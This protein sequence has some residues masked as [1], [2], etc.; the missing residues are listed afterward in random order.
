MQRICAI[1]V[2]NNNNDNNNN[3]N[4]NAQTTFG[5]QHLL[6]IKLEAQVAKLAS[7]QVIVLSLVSDSQVCC[8][9]FDHLVWL[10]LSHSP[11]LGSLSQEWL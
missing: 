9:L 8:G 5:T 2:L 4:N 10:A 6:A 1:H 3:N 7:P 11:F